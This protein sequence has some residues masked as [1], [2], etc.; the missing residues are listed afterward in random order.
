MQSTCNLGASYVTRCYRLFQNASS[1]STRLA[2]MMAACSAISSRKFA[3]KQSVR[4]ITNWMSNMHASCTISP[5]SIGAMGHMVD[6]MT[7]TIIIIIMAGVSSTSFTTTAV[8]TTTSETT[9]RL[10]PSARTRTLS[11]DAYMASTPITRMTSSVPTR[12]TKRTPNCA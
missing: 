6:A 2:R 12:A 11:P 3:R 7:A 5:A 9:R 1:Q 8:T 4:C 10:P